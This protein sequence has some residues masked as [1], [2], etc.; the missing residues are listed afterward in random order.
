MRFLLSLIIWVVIVG[1][2]WQY[3]AL[4][5]AGLV[6]QVATPVDL[7]AQGAVVIEITPTFNL[8]E[9]PF[10]LQTTTASASSI[11][12]ALNS[13]QVPTDSIELTRGKV[14]RI[15]DVQGL[16]QGHNDIYV[17]ASPP[18]AESDLEQGLRIKVFVDDVLLDEHTIWSSN[19]ALVSGS[20]SF[21]YMQEEGDHDH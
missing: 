12:I 4:R 16:L 5:D 2:L 7:S 13:R 14:A 9:D 17:K 20:F 11:E 3:T 19:G 15:D 6:K 8:E 1:G 10:A 18:L 21:K